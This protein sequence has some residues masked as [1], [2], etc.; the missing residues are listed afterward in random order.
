MHHPYRDRLRKLGLF[1]LEERR[2]QGNLI[3]AFHFLKGAYRKAGE[4]LL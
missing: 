1:S 3:G 4:G 2:L